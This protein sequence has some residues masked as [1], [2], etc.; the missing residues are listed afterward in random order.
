MNAKHM[1]QVGIMLSACVVLVGC[2]GGSTPTAER[3]LAAMPTATTVDDRSYNFNAE[4]QPAPMPTATVDDRSYNFNAE[5]QPAPVPT[6]TLDDGSYNFN[7]I[8][9]G[10]NSMH[11]G[12]D[13]LQRLPGDTNLRLREN[14]MTGGLEAYH[15]PELTTAGD[16]IVFVEPQEKEWFLDRYPNAELIRQ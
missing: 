10:R 8:E 9:I 11:C 15:V 5:R 1:V 2:G 13:V 7:F 16:C 4:R 12:Y 6:A 3:Q 14:F